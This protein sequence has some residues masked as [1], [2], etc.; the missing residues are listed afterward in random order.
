MGFLLP[1]RCI[2]EEDTLLNPTKLFFLLFSALVMQYLEMGNLLTA[3]SYFWNVPIALV[4]LGVLK[5]FYQGLR[6][7]MKYRK[8]AMQGIV[9]L[10]P[11]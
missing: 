5:F 4:A 3:A 10:P 7:R 6:I 9:R 2:A 8:L 11:P 1:L